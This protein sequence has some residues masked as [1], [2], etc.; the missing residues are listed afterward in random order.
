MRIRILTWSGKMPVVTM[1]PTLRDGQ[2]TI[3]LI[4]PPGAGAMPVIVRPGE[5]LIFTDG[6]LLV[7]DNHAGG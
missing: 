4:L 1:A 6:E 3:T 7:D 5:T 2:A